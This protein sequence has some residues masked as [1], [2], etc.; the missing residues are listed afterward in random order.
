MTKETKTN[1]MLFC[2]AIVGAII[3]KW[4]VSGL[5]TQ[6]EE[7]KT[8]I[9][10]EA[11]SKINAGLPMNVDSE[12]ILIST[13]GS[14]NNFTYN[15][16]L[17][18]HLKEDIDISLFN[19]AMIPNITNNVCTNSGMEA[20][21]ELGITITYRYFDSNNNEITHIDVDTNACSNET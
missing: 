20:F 21:R 18:E 15:Y 2:C 19:K 14:M 12:T 11:A 6:T 3:G 1:V 8:L 4:A 13:S 16:E 7:D 9:L 5:F 17:V 10:M